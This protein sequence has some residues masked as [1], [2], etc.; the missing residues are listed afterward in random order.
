MA[1]NLNRK[2]NI[3]EEN[4]IY[5]HHTNTKL[6][7]PVDPDAISDSMGASFA[8]NFPLSRSAPIYSYQNSGPRTVAVNFTIHRDLCNEYNNLGYDAVDALI[9]NLDQMVLPDYNAAGKIVNP[10]VVSLKLRDDIFIKGI[11]TNCSHTFQL[12]IINYGTEDSPSFKYAVVGLNFAVSE[13]T[14]YSASIIPNIGQYRNGSG[15]VASSSGVASGV[16]T[17][18][19]TANENHGN[20]S[21]GGG[22]MTMLTR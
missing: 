1:F 17:G 4:Y 15:W 11:V 9:T 7:I 8:S 14:P 6:I 16:T 3:P 10:P 12:P 20:T 21:G 19:M 5:F 13:T 22:I 2:L 18:A